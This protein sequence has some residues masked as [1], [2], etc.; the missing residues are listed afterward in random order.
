MN[1]AQLIDP[2]WV[3]DGARERFKR[4]RPAAVQAVEPQT[5]VVVAEE[6]GER[7]AEVMPSPITG[8]VLQD[9][10][11]QREKLARLAAERKRQ[12]EERAARSGRV[13]GLKGRSHAL[14]ALLA[15]CPE[16]L[17]SRQVREHAQEQ[18]PDED[19][20]WVYAMLTNLA[21]GRLVS[22]R[23][24]NAGAVYLITEAGRARVVPAAARWTREP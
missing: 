8:E 3:M 5:R 22:T 24:C 2:E 12:R 6:M 16:G 4:R 7:P 23:V 11:R 1:F 21:N 9:V 20:R 18:A 15:Q 14:L 19:S 17:L 13:N 10:R